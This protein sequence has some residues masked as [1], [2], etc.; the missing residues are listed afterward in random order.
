M[1]LKFV[2]TELNFNPSKSRPNFLY[3]IVNVI[4][5][6]LIIFRRFLY[7]LNSKRKELIVD[8]GVYHD[9]SHLGNKG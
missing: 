9:F 3:D 1:I 6:L 8:K 5:I 2:L 4:V 7:F